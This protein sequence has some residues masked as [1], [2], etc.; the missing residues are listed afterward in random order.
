[1]LY[2]SFRAKLASEPLLLAAVRVGGARDWGSTA[3]EEVTRFTSYGN[4]VGMQYV[5]MSC[6][7]LARQCFINILAFARD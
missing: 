6:I 4:T 1:M 2:R 5:C 3:V 7:L